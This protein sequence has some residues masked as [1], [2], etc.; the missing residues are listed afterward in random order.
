MAIRTFPTREMDKEQTPSALEFV[1][2]DLNIVEAAL[3]QNGRTASTKLGNKDV[4]ALIQQL[5][6]AQDFGGK[7]DY[8]GDS[9]MA[10]NVLPGELYSEDGGDEDFDLGDEGDLG[11]EGDDEFGTFD[12][13]DTEAYPQDGG[14]DDLDFTV[15]SHN[16]EDEM[17]SD[18]AGVF[19][20]ALGRVGRF[21][22]KMPPEL[23]EHFKSKKKGNGKKSEDAEDA[24]GEES[25]DDCEDSMVRK[26]REKKASRPH[27]THPSQ[28]NG[29]AL[30]AAEAAGDAV[31]HRAIQAARDDRRRALAQVF[32]NTTVEL[33]N[34]KRRLAE[35]DAFRET[36]V[37]VAEAAEARQAQRIAE[38]NAKPT[39]KSPSEL[40]E[41]ERK[42]FAAKALAAGFPQEYVEAMLAQKT[43]S[44]LPTVEPQL[45]EVAASKMSDDTK[46]V[47]IA[48]LVKVANLDQANISH[49]IDYWVNQLG[50][51]RE[52]AEAL[53]AKK[54]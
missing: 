33:E 50:Y 29:E 25:E 41:R 11:G 22:G 5:R 39:F 46:R 14:E 52:W 10:D 45:R 38:A 23:L 37:R 3:S 19:A 7:D 44:A 16:N 6:V 1:P 36:L 4:D 9:H 30:E 17:D 51:D 48:S 40:N 20:S 53:F 18:V 2:I 28:I 47:A 32:V 31:L 24:E 13:D 26:G 42:T 15:P 35:R 43:Q 8:F 54:Y 21:A 27:F 34:L 12:L 49:C